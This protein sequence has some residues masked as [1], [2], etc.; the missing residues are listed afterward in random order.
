[1]LSVVW[2]KY[3]DPVPEPLGI[4]EFIYADGGKERRNNLGRGQQ[5]AFL[6]RNA[7][8]EID[9]WEP[10][11]QTELVGNTCL[12]TVVQRTLKDVFSCSGLGESFT[13]YWF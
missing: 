2:E 11:H 7:T 10:G 12:R 6:C 8:L 13:T 3:S 9:I 1:M 4:R 5:H